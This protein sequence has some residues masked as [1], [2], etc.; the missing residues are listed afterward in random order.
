MRFTSEMKTHMTPLCMN[1]NIK[2]GLSLPQN[3]SFV[4]K[5]VVSHIFSF[6]N[7]TYGNSFS[8]LG[9]EELAVYS[10]F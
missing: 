1:E 4:P 5:Q 2:C 10:I 6:E 8:M 7:S 3:V 9:H